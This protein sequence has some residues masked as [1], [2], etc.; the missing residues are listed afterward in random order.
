MKEHVQR[1][2]NPV[3]FA[4]GGGSQP[5]QESLSFNG[6]KILDGE[7]VYVLEECPPALSIGKAVIDKG[8]MFIW[9]HGK[10]VPYLVAPENI[11]RC[12]VKVPKNA[13]IRASRVV[14]YVPQ[15]D[16]EL[17]PCSFE[18]SE[19]LAPVPNA[20]PAPSV[21]PKILAENR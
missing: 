5:G 10:N 1:S 15:Y 7:E 9:T 14:E 18:P 11:N 19:R 6:S 12:R 3:A 17:S 13:R 21:E 8:Y 20:M 4:T 2:A 16:E